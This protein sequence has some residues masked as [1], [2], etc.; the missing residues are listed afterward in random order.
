MPATPRSADAKPQGRHLRYLAVHHK[1]QVWT[2]Y[3]IP[4]QD[5]RS[6]RKSSGSEKLRGKQVKAVANSGRHEVVAVGGN[7]VEAGARNF[8]HEAVRT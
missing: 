1:M 8:G 4:R 5:L 3:T 7:T 6:V 2:S